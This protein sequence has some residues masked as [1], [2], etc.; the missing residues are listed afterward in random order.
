MPGLGRDYRVERPAGRLPVLER[1][2]LDPQ[3]VSFRELGHPRIWLDPE[4]GAAGG[5]ELPARDAGSTA[6]VEQVRTRASGDDPLHQ[7]TGIAG[8]S[9]VVTLHVRTER[10]GHRPGLVQLR[11]GRLWLLPR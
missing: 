11:S 2:H 8:P 1:R 5:L 10:L 7:C 4:D 9:L 3:A 6:H